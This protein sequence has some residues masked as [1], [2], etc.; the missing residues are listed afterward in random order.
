MLMSL[1][2]PASLLARK[3]EGGERAHHCMPLAV[4]TNLAYDAL[5]FAN[6]SLEAGIGRHWS[7]SAEAICPWWNAS[8]NTSTTQMLNF[9]LETRFY[10][11]GWK[12]CRRALSGPYVGLHANGGIYDIA[13]PAGVTCRVRGFQGDYFAMGGAVIGYSLPLGDWWRIDC[14]LGLGAMYTEYTHY[15]LVENKY[16]MLHNKG[17]YTWYGPTKANFSLVWMMGQMWHNSKKGGKK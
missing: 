14:T 1:M 11:H 12:D 3:S 16:L 8:D 15:D 4:K 13:R 2:M 17:T 6:L 9:G 7:L 10:W 5:T